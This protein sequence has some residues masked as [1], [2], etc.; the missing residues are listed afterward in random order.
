M[1]VRLG[2]I[3][4]VAV[5]VTA[6]TV[7]AP[8]AEAA[9]SNGCVLVAHRG[10][11]STTA[12]ENGMR[13]MRSA[14]AAGAEYLEVDVRTTRDDR[15]VLM[16]DPKV[17]RTTDGTGQVA[18]RTG[19]QVRALRLDDGGRV[20]YVAQVLR[21]AADADVRVLVDVKAMGGSDSY[22]RLASA[23]RQ[24]GGGRVTVMAFDRAYLDRMGKFAPRVKKAVITWQAR[25][26]EE[27]APYRKV[28][29]H[30]EAVTDEWLASMNAA[31]IDVFPW[32]VDSPEDWNRFA[33]KVDG[34]ITNDPRGYATY[35]EAAP[36]CQSG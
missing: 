30:H 22:K 28:A 34:V 26:P 9:S 35:R 8:A 13:A 25:T 2:R 5:A 7:G 19:K 17:D 3:T 31:E 11:H 20:P 36:G 29:V 33:G 24:Y 4:A 27:L 10:D 15:V 21:L 14:V 32:T 16:H 1:K 23:I 6:S 12:T 18:R